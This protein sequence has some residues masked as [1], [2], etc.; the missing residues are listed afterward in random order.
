MGWG[1]RHR[2][3]ESRSESGI[4]RTSSG[5]DCNARMGPSPSRT[6][7]ASLPS[8]DD[9]ATTGPKVSAAKYKTPNRLR[10]QS[11][12]N[13]VRSYGRCC[14]E[15]A[16][17]LIGEASSRFESTVAGKKLPAA[18]PSGSAA[19]QTTLAPARRCTPILLGV[20]DQ[21]VVSKT[22]VALARR[23]WH[24]RRPRRRPAPRRGRAA[25]TRPAHATEVPEPPGGHTRRLTP[26]VSWVYLE[27]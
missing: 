14:V 4:K 10:K 6:A 16:P 13:A 11:E 25:A 18:P 26:T 17:V 21:R 7:S 24:R 20:E 1:F 23:S 19:W 8:K 27:F 9:S 2:G 12:Q 22:I 3:A 15:S 5:A